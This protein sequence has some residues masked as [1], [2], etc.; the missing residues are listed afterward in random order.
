MT[1][2]D[3]KKIAIISALVC[4]FSCNKPNDTINVIPQP[5]EV[6]LDGNASV[7]IEGAC[8]IVEPGFE[9]P[10]AEY[11]MN[12]ASV[13]HEASAKQ[14]GAEIRFIPDN[15]LGKEEY[16]M[17]V[18]AKGVRIKASGLNGV[19]YAVQTLKQLL[20]VEIYTGTCATDKDWSVPC[21]TVRDKPRFAYRGMHL[22]PCRHFFSVEETKRYIDIMEL[23]KM[24]TLHW[25]LTE[26]Q[27]WRVEIKK[28]PRL[29]E[30]GSMRKETIIGHTKEY[31]GTPYGGYYTQEQIREVVAYAAARGITIIPEVDLPGHMQ[32]ALAA[33]PE[34]G[35]TGGPYEVWCRWGVSENVLC[36]GKEEVFTFLEDVIS[37]LC[38]LFPGEYF[39]IGGDE[40]PKV[41][42]HDCPLCQAKIK[43]LGI[44]GNEKFTPEDFLQSYVTKRMEDF[45]A[46][47]GRK[48]IGWDE[49]LQGELS[50]NATVMS[51][52]GVQG[53]IT[54]S[55]MGHDVIM[56]PNIFC[57]FDYC[58]SKDRDA[59]PISIGGYLPIDKVYE[60]EPCP[61]EMTKD[62][63]SHILGVQAN[64]WTEYVATPEHLEYMI[65]PREAALCE[66]Q[67]CQ[68]E[69]KD[70]ERF[71][72]ALPHMCEIYEQRGYNY[73][74]HAL[75]PDFKPLKQ[76][77]MV[78]NKAKGKKAQAFTEPHP[79]Y[80]LHAPLELFDGIKGENYFGSGDWIGYYGKP[81]DVVVK[82]GGTPFSAITLSTLVGKP[83]YI[84]NLTGYRISTS[85]NG[86]EFTE[87]AHGEYEVDGPDAPNDVRAFRIEFPETKAKYLKIEAW[88]ADALPQWH[89]GA[90]NTPFLFLDEIIVE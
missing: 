6:H 28:Y 54:A 5:M 55:Q 62:Q 26:D 20:P 69:R 58:Q 49:I 19:V 42:W 25:H 60:F 39:H 75:S 34:L 41:R 35:C 30:I 65:L 51:W 36:V 74:K 43:E 71:H 14:S 32:A 64:M 66:V 8:V 53:G 78:E 56:T 22:D 18:S 17:R 63:K 70:W 46:T 83:D 13:L 9:K 12:F 90:G 29:T 24:N 80:T 48:I 79:S 87:I 52:R 47:K 11:A 68:S 85:R 31:D 27:G 50:P 38:E 10:A 81:L 76:K 21:M 89:P 88:T 82:M 4:I 45:L 57:Y 33:Y 15:R 3:M 77:T 72:A 23:H 37:E 86:K 84:L 59:E 73:A 1:L 67:W 7:D 2:S 44:T 61:N 40:C 16:E